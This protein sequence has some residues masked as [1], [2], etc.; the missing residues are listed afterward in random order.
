MRRNPTKILALQL[1]ILLILSLTA[2]S[3]RRMRN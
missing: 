1:A 2:C 3:A